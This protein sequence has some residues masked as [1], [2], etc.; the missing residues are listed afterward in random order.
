LQSVAGD[1]PSFPMINTVASRQ[2]ALAAAIRPRVPAVY[3]TLPESVRSPRANWTG[4]R[5]AEVVLLAGGVRAK[6]FR[7]QVGRSPL[8]LPLDNGRCLI[9]LWANDVAMLSECIGL[10]GVRARVLI[11]SVGESGGGRM[12]IERDPAAYR[13]T[14]GVLRDV[15][16]GVPGDHYVLV[17]HASQ[18]LCEPLVSLVERL[19]ACAA[20]LSFPVEPGGAAGGVFLIRA[21]CLGAIPEVGFVDLKEQAIPAIA[22]KHRVRVV[23]RSVPSGLPV[24]TMAEYLA[25][26]RHHHLRQ[27]GHGSAGFSVIEP[28]ASVH[29]SARV[30]DSV[31]LAGGRVEAGAIVAGSV[32]GGA[33]VVEAGRRVVHSLIG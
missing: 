25:A 23:K 1:G 29:P 26:V 8:D 27:G 3:R 11:D 22:A 20:D 4:P 28:G 16:R 14:G 24:R 32:V 10:E 30:H 17:C 6:G 18:V 7:A 13:G 15:C 33:G 21:G 2:G 9:D 31:V 5:V 12:V 19:G